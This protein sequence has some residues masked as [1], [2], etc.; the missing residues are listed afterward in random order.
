MPVRAVYILD[1]GNH[2]TPLRLSH[3]VK[4]KSNGF[5]GDHLKCCS[6]MSALG[7]TCREA[8]TV[9]SQNETLRL[10]KEV[11]R[12]ET[13]L[14]DVNNRFYRFKLGYGYA[15]QGCYY[16]DCAM[17]ERHIDECCCDWICDCKDCDED[18]EHMK[19]KGWTD[20]E[21]RAIRRMPEPAGCMQV[22]DVC[23]AAHDEECKCDW[24]CECR[25]CEELR[26]RLECDGWTAQ[27]LKNYNRFYR[28]DPYYP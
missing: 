16:G 25:V 11:L 2:A 15:G 6:S 13:E 26:D 19:T 21:M 9:F 17:C 23:G 20:D 14:A 7:L 18:R 27:Q 1:A 4:N 24:T 12:L 10:Q 3:S 5:D 8:F 22:C 28:L